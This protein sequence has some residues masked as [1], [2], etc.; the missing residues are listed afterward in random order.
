MAILLIE[1]ETAYKL[2]SYD[3][4]INKLAVSKARE[5]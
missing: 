2:L 4:V 3:E 1:T 5:I